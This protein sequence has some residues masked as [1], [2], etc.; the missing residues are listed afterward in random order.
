MTTT[1]ELIIESWYLSKIV[2][3]GLGTVSGAQI[4][5]GLRLL[6]SLL[7]FKTVDENKIPYFTEYDFQSIVGEEK[8]FIPGLISV[9]TL[10]FELNSVRYS[11]QSMGRKEYFGSPRAN[12]I[13]SLP[14]TYHIE[15]ALNGANLFMYA[16]PN[17]VYPF[18]LYANFSLQSV[19]LNE[20]L[21][22]TL[23]AFYIEY[24]RYLLSAYMC[25]DY[26]VSTPDSVA[27][28]LQAYEDKMIDVSPYDFTMKKYSILNAQTTGPD[29]YVNANITTWRPF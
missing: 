8:Y 12:N 29:I 15:R 2:P 3:R 25:E 5:D 9:Q 24:M 18:K 28:R 26:G 13:K 14:F 21:N 10:T 17:A 23:D 11:M 22:D 27:K 6:N 16:L 1:R 19:T 20:D 4:N 7:A